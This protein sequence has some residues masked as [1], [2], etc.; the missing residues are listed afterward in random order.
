MS[1]R[2]LEA[3]WQGG[4]EAMLETKQRQDMSEID[5]WNN[6]NDWEMTGECPLISY[7]R[8]KRCPLSAQMSY[9]TICES[10]I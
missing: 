3:G 2:N 10:D 7:D 5:Q 1:V 9:R 4:I 8:G 6:R